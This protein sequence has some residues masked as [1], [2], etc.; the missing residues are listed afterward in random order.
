[1]CQP[2]SSTAHNQP[3]HRSR[4]YHFHVMPVRTR[5]GVTE[6]QIE[7]ARAI[8]GKEKEGGD[9]GL[10]GPATRFISGE[11]AGWKKTQLIKSPLLDARGNVTE[12]IFKSHK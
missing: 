4:V 9:G 10:W 11:A 12:V 8:C 7:R 1:M 6:R 5:E 3:V 2:L